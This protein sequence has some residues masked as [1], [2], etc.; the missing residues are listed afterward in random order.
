MISCGCTVFFAF[1]LVCF[2]GAAFW[3][4]Q[5]ICSQALNETRRKRSTNKYD[6]ETGNVTDSTTKQQKRT[7]TQIGTN[8]NQM[9]FIFDLPQN[10]SHR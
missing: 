4:V 1:W 8:V 7:L 9:L 2:L 5:E 10:I 3:K 6:Y